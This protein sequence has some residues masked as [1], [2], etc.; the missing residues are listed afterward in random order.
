LE[1]K[2]D[3]FFYKNEKPK[4]MSKGFGPIIAKGWFFY[5]ILIFSKYN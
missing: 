3:I 1:K 4:P 2:L 5:L